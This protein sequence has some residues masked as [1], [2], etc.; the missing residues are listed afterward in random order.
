MSS[1]DYTVGV[2]LQRMDLHEQALILARLA[3]SRFSENQ[4]TPKHLEE[5]FCGFALPKPAK[6]SN[7][8]AKLRKDGLITQGS[9]TATWRMTPLGRQTSLE[10]L[11]D[12]DL[13]GFSA[14]SASSSSFLGQVAHAVVPPALAPPSLIPG[15]R[16][17]L[18][19]HPF[20]TNVFGMTRFPESGENEKGPDP[21]QPALEIAREVCRLHGLEFHLASD[22]AI[23]DDLWANVAAHMWASQ[24]GIAFFEDRRNRGLNYNLTIEV[25]SMLITG[26]RCALLKD[27]SIPRMPT[28]LVGKIYKSVDLKKT[29]S[30]SDALHFW[31]RD[32]LNL[33]SCSACPSTGTSVFKTV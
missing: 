31:F 9:Q 11:S 18:K 32:D 19:Q 8:I 2:R 12:L 16:R 10:L 30:I 21:V 24:Y 6:I 20:E 17:F 14:E 3:Q 13:A 33:G 28:D 22:R 5:L 29:K 25:G 15:L 26:R 1:G 4:F 27:C 7:I 23:D